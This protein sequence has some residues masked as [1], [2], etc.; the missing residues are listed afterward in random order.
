[1]MSSGAPPV[2]AI[3]CSRELHEPQKD[4]IRVVFVDLLVQLGAIPLPIAN[5]PAAAQ[6]VANCQGLLLTGGGDFDPGQFGWPDAGT[7]WDTVSR[8]RDQTELS[9]ILQA[10]SLQ[11]PIFG[12]CRGAQAMALAMGGTLVQD[13]GRAFPATP[14]THFQT[15]PRFQ[16]SHRV[17]PA[18]NS[19][20]AQIVGTSALPVNSF[21]HQAIAEMPPGWTV[22]ARSD[23]GLIEAIEQDHAP[24]RIGVQWHPEDLCGRDRAAD[25]LFQE[26]VAAAWQVLPSR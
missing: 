4:T 21:H 22:S 11:L 10:I 6:L 15:E 9:A 24:W 5:V 8:E 25:R 18:A 26:F 7:N 17:Y 3:T 23:D 2:I 13:I 14:I 16:T 20:L 19:R 12:I 1:M